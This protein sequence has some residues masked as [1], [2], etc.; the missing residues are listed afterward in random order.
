MDEENK[1]R[2]EL[3]A[4]GRLKT[5]NPFR[6]FFDK[7]AAE[8]YIPNRE[9]I[10][11]STALGGQNMNCGLVGGWM[12]YFC[13]NVLKIQPMYVGIIT[14]IARVW[15]GVNDPIAGT[16][17]DR[18]PPKNG[19]K[20]HRY[21]GKIAVV[22]GILTVLM[23]ADFHFSEAGAIVW[24]L[25]AY[26]L[27]D[28]AFSFQDV[29][30]WGTL[31][32]MSP[33]SRERTRAAQWVTIGASAGAGI[34]GVIPLLMSFSKKLGISESALFFAAGLVF[35]LGGELISMLAL[36]THER[37]L[38]P[39][40][41]QKESFLHQIAAIRHNKILICLVLAQTL[42][43]LSITVPWIY[44]FKYCVS[45]QLGGTPVD[46][47]TVQMI[48][49]ILAFIPGNISMFLATKLTDKLGGT[50]RTL[51]VAQIT[52]ITVRV[53]CFFV[54]YN[55]LPRFLIMTL[56]MAL[57]SI[58]TGIMGIVNRAFL[59]DSIDYMEWKTGKRTEGI[60]SSL[61]NFVAKISSALQSLISGALLQLLHFDNSL[62]GI[63]GQAPEFYKWQWPLFILGPA[64]G[65]AL[66]LIPMLF[67]H[68]TPKEKEQV[69]QE[70]IRRR[71][72]KA[73]Q[74]AGNVSSE[75]D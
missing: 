28:T 55:T 49:S 64:V 10:Y 63:A 13:T 32:L 39:P 29:A 16:L 30:L 8:G 44:F 71:E 58:P 36:K 56:L 73:R 19:S 47:E 26:I 69:E 24:F 48:Y 5:K 65:A 74:E 59:C 33:H 51:V 46:G 25:A 60:V 11:F 15:D 42:N 67:L 70:L 31:S 75:N 41:E 37:I 52:A 50:K 17:I 3:T 14:S 23:F 45:F 20:L 18:I 22:I 1:G 53:L 4:E 12:F 40:A 35:G 34:V 72:E 61:Q 54:G 7:R 38:H 6:F 9:L 21:L 68:Y 43:G 27:W 62:D 2:I 57:S 66:Y